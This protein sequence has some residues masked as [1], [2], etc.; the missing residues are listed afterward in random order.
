VEVEVVAMV[1][2][3][4]MEYMEAEMGPLDDVTLVDVPCWG[5]LRSSV[6]FQLIPHSDEVAHSNFQMFSRELVGSNYVE[7]ILS[8]ELVCTAA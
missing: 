5:S 4:A 1:I 3:K 2:S 7:R 8:P 6:L